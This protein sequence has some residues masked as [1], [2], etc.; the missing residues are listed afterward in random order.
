MDLPSLRTAG[1]LASRSWGT[2][3]VKGLRLKRSIGD[4]GTC[5]TGERTLNFII[6]V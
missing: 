6:I 3:N 5:K 1:G 2:V 4:E